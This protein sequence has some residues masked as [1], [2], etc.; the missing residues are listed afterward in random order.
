MIFSINQATGEESSVNNGSNPIANLASK[1]V[2]LKNDLDQARCLA[3]DYQKQLSDKTNA[4]AA[5]KSRMGRMQGELLLLEMTVTRVRRENQELA[6]EAARA[7]S[8][9][10]TVSAMSGELLRQRVGSVQFV[11]IGDE[12]CESLVLLHESVGSPGKHSRV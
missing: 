11:K 8:M 5:L 10:A 3:E 1:Y 7:K 4:F 12:N 9:D 6:K 2:A